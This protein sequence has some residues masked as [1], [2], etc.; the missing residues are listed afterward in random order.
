MFNEKTVRK[1]KS[2]LSTVLIDVAKKYGWNHQK[3]KNNIIELD[4]GI[5]FMDIDFKGIKRFN[6]TTIIEHPKQG[7][8]ELTREGVELDELIGIIKNP[9]FHTGKG[10]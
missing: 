9:R 7:Y 6:V 10:N 3:T 2:V 5:D 4:K 1:Y 8:N